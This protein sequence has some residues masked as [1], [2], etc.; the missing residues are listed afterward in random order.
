[1]EAR[2]MNES[3]S[4]AVRTDSGCGPR[5]P[6]SGVLGRR[7]GGFNIRDTERDVVDTVPSMIEESRETAASGK[8]LHQLD[9]GLPHR[10]K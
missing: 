7:H 3:D 1:M 8:R 9:F 6:Q 4:S 5:E 10:K 2:W